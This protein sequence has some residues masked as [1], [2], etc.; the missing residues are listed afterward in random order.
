[1]LD[2]T[3]TGTNWA[4]FLSSF[5]AGTGSDNIT[6]FVTNLAGS[7]AAGAEMGGPMGAAMAG[8][9][10][11]IQSMASQIGAGRREA[12]IIVPVQNQVWEVLRVM[13][14]ETN[15][16]AAGQPATVRH[17]LDFYFLTVDTYRRFD[18]FTRDPRFTDGRASRQARDTIRPYVD[19][20]NDAG[21]FDQSNPYFPKG[22]LLGSIER[23]VVARGGVAPGNAGTGG[24]T[25]TASDEE[26]AQ[27]AGAGSLTAGAGGPVLLVAG[28]A[29]LAK[30]LK[31]F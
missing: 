26:Y 12:D 7:I 17:L 6:G 20:K 5:G 27:L 9:S 21:V 22:G 28:A 4:S 29:I 30:L 11:L 1:M 19:G 8:A 25:K 10:S 24:N 16:V 23:L 3:G 15:L 14:D 31:L 18:R 2:N 13:I